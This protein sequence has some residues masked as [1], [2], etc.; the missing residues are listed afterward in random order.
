MEPSVKDQLVAGRI[1][2]RLNHQPAEDRPATGGD[3][4]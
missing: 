4:P 3:D 2:K 1:V